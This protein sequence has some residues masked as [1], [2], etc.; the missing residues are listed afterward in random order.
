MTTPPPN[1]VRRVPGSPTSPSPSPKRSKGQDDALASNSSSPK[2]KLHFAGR[3]YRTPDESVS[4][5]RLKYAAGP[6]LLGAPDELR[7]DEAYEALGH[8]QT[9]LLASP[10]LRP[11]RP[12]DTLQI[13]EPACN[14]LSD[15]DLEV[16]PPSSPFKT[17]TK[18]SSSSI[19]SLSAKYNLT[20]LNVP[21]PESY[22]M[23]LN[24]H[25]AFE[26][27]L[28]LHLTTEGK[29]GR[30]ASAVS[31]SAADFSST[32]RIRLE[33]LATYNQLRAMVERGSGRRFGQTEFA[34]L[35]WL[36]NAASSTTSAVLDDPF[37]DSPAPVS[38]LG[39]LVT[40]TTEMSKTNGKKMS[41][42]GIG[43]ELDL[44][45]NGEATERSLSI[46][47]SPV[48]AKKP[49]SP[50]KMAGKREGMSV[51]ALWSQGA[52][53]RKNEIR[54][55]LGNCVVQHHDSF[56]HS[57]A[58]ERPS[59]PISRPRRH[60]SEPSFH[61]DFDLCALPSVPTS[62]LPD[63]LGVQ[64]STGQ[65]LNGLASSSSSPN[66][67]ENDA[68]TRKPSAKVRASSLTERIKAKEQAQ[69]A[70]TTVDGQ[71]VARVPNLGML[72][73]TRKSLKANSA[74]A[75]RERQRMAEFKRKSMLSR[76]P[77]VADAVYMLF[78]PAMPPSPG[79]MSTAASRYRRAVPLDEVCTNVA[80][81][82]KIALSAIEAKEA[83]ALLTDICPD[84]VTLRK[85]EGRDWLMMNARTGE[86]MNLKEC[87]DEL[88]RILV[89]SL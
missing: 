13:P 23:L 75:E 7:I 27:A 15:S 80:K 24:L 38:S 73:P 45:R 1:R 42:W 63:L 55:R 20:S 4:P 87:K 70:G 3:V 25:T 5:K 6:D 22:Q 78:A 49:T 33:N 76:M 50:N 89:D 8:Q 28:M 47:N 43:I 10:T 85:I 29:G 79:S 32:S 57:I 17:P 81:S 48:S 83:I 60:S 72:S 65:T 35:L 66:K 12:K 86:G 39:F 52:E 54:L 84:F 46:Q 36:W 14:A 31:A 88:K 2:I 53:E 74:A 37:S 59:T 71:E 51:V 41:S 58:D 56:L 82:S 34:Q 18:A 62:T 68:T 21:L 77:N 9:S 69:N 16:E 26:R 19:S 40:K 11:V 67:S 44:K 30:I 61:P 64:R